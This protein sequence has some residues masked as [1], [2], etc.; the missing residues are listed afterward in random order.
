MRKLLITVVAMMALTMV[1]VPVASAATSPLSYTGQGFGTD[2]APSNSKCDVGDN[3]GTGMAIP[4][5]GRYLLWVLNGSVTNTVANPPKLIINGTT[6]TMVK[7]GSTWKVVTPYYTK[8]QLVGTT[9]VVFTGSANNLVVSHGCA[10]V[11]S[12]V[13]TDIHNANHGVITS[14]DLGAT[15]HDTATV[16]SSA[17]L[18]SGSKVKFTFYKGADVVGTETKDVVNNSVEDA[19]PEGPLHAGSYSYKAE[20]ISGNTNLVGNSIAA[21]EPL[22]IAKGE[23]NITTQIHGVNT[24]HNNVGDAVSVPLGSTVHDTATVA[25]AAGSYD[26]FTIPGADDVSFTRNGFNIDKLAAGEAGFT[27][28]TVESIPLS[29][30]SWT[31]K[32]HVNGNSDYNADDSP[33]EPLTV[34]KAQLSITTEIHNDAHGAILSAVEGSIVHDTATVSG[35]VAGFDPTGAVSFTL[36]GNAVGSDNGNVDAIR[37]VDSDP[38]VY[39]NSYT[40]AAHVDGDDNYI[41]ADSADEPLEVTRNTTGAFCSPGYWKNAPDAA[42]LKTGHTRTEMFNSSG[43]V[44]TFYVA[45]APDQTLEYVLN[46]NSQY[47]NAGPFNL[48]GANAVGAFLA[49]SL[50]GFH[51]DPALVGNEGLTG[52]PLDAHGDYKPGMDPNQP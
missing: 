5:D 4:A 37:S 12:Q 16:T 31:Y 23:L 2:G 1:A 13:R 52:C 40:Y 32:A 42:W 25:V 41:G 15:V 46:N 21:D 43:I 27:A 44:G 50:D 29:A 19:L 45:I 47:P 11:P 51:F 3:G 28:R 10:R 36:N 39:G 22:E 24:E 8:A 18:P 26:G 35:A 7:V 20:F 30:G 33:D 38:L 14:A 48:S 6:Y 49:N 9:S 34:D 17:S